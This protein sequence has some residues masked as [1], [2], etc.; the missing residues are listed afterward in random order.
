M[1]N[2]QGVLL[3]AFLVLVAASGLWNGVISPKQQAKKT[4]DLIDSLIGTDDERQ[5][6]ITPRQTEVSNADVNECL[7]AFFDHSITSKRILRALDTHEDKKLSTTDVIETINVA[8]VKK[9]SKPLP[10]YVIKSVIMNLMGAS[11]I[12][13]Q[14]GDLRPTPCGIKLFKMLEQRRAEMV[15]ASSDKK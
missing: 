6:S 5:T 13:L 4:K 15:S 12:T 1:D 2:I 14:D 3:L 8:L 7:L 9:G 11:I 10:E